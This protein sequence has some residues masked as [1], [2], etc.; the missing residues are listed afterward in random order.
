MIVTQK[1]IIKIGTSLESEQAYFC[2]KSLD[3]NLWR[4]FNLTFIIST[5][6]ARQFGRSNRAIGHDFR[7]QHC[8][9]R[10]RHSPVEGTVSNATVTLAS[11]LISHKLKLSV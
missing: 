4:W 2:S 1:E 10:E 9:P 3:V 7:Q 6:Q 5:F 8:C 11:I